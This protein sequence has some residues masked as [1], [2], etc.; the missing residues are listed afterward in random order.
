MGMDVD[1]DDEKKV[2]TVMEEDAADIEAAERRRLQEEA[3][4]LYEAR[5]SVV[6]RSELPRPVGVIPETSSLSHDTFERLIDEE[7]WTLLRHDA[8]AFP[9]EASPSLVEDKK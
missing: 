8:H 2:E 5:S 6:K 1:L 9:V 7:R 3:E 4:K